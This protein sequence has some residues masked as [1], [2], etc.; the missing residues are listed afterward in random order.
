[1]TTPPT[2]NI[3]DWPKLVEQV[4]I[5]VRRRVDAAWVDD[6]TGGVLLRLVENTNAL[7]AADNPAAYVQRV[8]QNA[9]TDFY[10]RRDVENRVLAETALEAERTSPA[11]DP[12]EPELDRSSE[13]AISRCLHPFIEDL[14]STYRDALT[15]TEIKRLSPKQ[16]AGKLG[17][18]GSGMKSRLQ[19]GRALLKRA[20]IRCCR[21]ETDPRGR[22]IDHQPRKA[23]ND[24]KC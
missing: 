15:L 9:V 21:I 1:M 12:G 2:I 8:T 16:A 7:Q 19:R 5:I 17:L 3:V 14:P 24:S 18:S 10:R 22:I 20:V 13:E 6:V 23:C 4:R 11:L